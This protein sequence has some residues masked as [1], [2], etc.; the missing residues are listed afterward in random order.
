MSSFA[1]EKS[2]LVK[3]A[4]VFLIAQPNTMTTDS[5]CA[6]KLDRFLEAWM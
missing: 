4:H 5:N 2:N 1:S 3:P 6:K